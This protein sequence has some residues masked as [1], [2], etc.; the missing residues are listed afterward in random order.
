MSQNLSIGELASETGVKVVMARYHERIGILPRPA[1]SAGSYR[2]YGEEHVRRLR[3]VPRC[4]DLGFALDQIRDRLR[5]PSEAAPSCTEVSSITAHH[6][7]AIQEKVND[8]VRLA[9][10]LRRINS[11]CNGN[12]PIGECRI[13]D[14]LSRN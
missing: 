13:L 2:I 10:E 7:E 11:S 5:L 14:A 3:L 6:L 8:L 4:R 1:R 9:R 12:R